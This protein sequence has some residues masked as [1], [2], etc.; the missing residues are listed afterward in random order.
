MRVLRRRKEKDKEQSE[1]GQKTGS[2]EMWDGKME[3][4]KGREGEERRGSC[5]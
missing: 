2:L 3:R 5:Q 1:R 4:K